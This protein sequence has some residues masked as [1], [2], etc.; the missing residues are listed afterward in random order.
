MTSP[1]SLD[2]LIAELRGWMIKPYGGIHA[3]GDL[4]GSAASAIERLREERDAALANERSMQRR[5]AAVLEDV[6]A[7]LVDAKRYRWLK[8]RAYTDAGE[9]GIV[10]FYV[11]GK[12]GSYAEFADEAVDAAL[13]AEPKDGA[14]T[15]EV[16]AFCEGLEGGK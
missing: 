16:K 11:M 3:V 10:G 13:A 5:L 14:A 15:T 2:G 8:E 9:Q 12:P 6:S 1:D 4:M 7:A